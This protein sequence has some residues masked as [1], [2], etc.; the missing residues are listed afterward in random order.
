M[1]G[2]VLVLGKSDSSFLTV[3]RSLGRRGIDVH[4]AWC[5][6]TEVARR[7]RYVRAEH[8]LPPFRP[9][10]DAWKRA[11]IDLC[12]RER[13]DLVIPTNDPTI[14]PLQEHRADLEP[15]AKIYLLSETAYRVGYDKQRSYDVCRE[16]GVR[17]PQ[18]LVLP[19]PAD[20]AEV[21]RRFSL[22]VVVKARSSFRSED[23]GDRRRT[24]VARDAD[25]LRQW[26]HVLVGRADEVLIEEY[27]E[28]EGGGIDMLCADG[29]VLH[30]FQHLRLHEGRGYSSAPYRLSEPVHQGMLAD[31]RKFVRALDYTGVL[32][33]EFRL[34]RTTDDWLFHDFNARF[35]AALPLTVASGADYPYWL[36]QV[37]VE[38]KR[39]F[40]QAYRSGI[41]CRNWRLDLLWVRENLALPRAERTPLR[42][43]A[44]EAWR[45]ATLREWSD[46]LVAD[47]PVPG[48]V[49]MSR[50]AAR[51][52]RKLN[53]VARLF[54]SSAR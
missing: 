33:M 54:P 39:D 37:L 4:I 24:R 41:A 50:I 40:P 22:P 52:W 2:K 44:G 21:L 46:T 17:F 53:P 35:W 25:G 26:L 15:H 43:I 29:E 23:L 14:I 49:D 3:I 32:M 1:T 18:H 34:N 30:A 42:E 13:F 10:D 12:A 16:V 19:V 45:F 28:G 48:L 27:F 5:P 6:P 7:S 20:P 31:A 11:L 9:D 8:Q 38:G 36:Y 47:D 51:G